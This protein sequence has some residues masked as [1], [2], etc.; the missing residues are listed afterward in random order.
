[1]PKLVINWYQLHIIIYNNVP[2]HIPHHWSLWLK[3]FLIELLHSLVAYMKS[4]VWN[5]YRMAWY[6]YV[7]LDAFALTISEITLMPLLKLFG[8]AQSS[9]I[10]RVWKMI[11]LPGYSLSRMVD[12]STTCLRG[13]PF[14]YKIQNAFSNL[15]MC[16]K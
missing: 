5:Y 3:V 11:H 8:T 13:S 15:I 12:V 4:N 7:C 16:P 6:W 14:C 9:L 10:G 1:L 2:S